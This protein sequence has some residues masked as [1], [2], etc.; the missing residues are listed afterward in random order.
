MTRSSQTDRERAE[1]EAATWL[2][3]LSEDP[4]DLA[5]AARFE[6]WRS[7]HPLHAELWAR[8]VRAYELAGGTP[9]ARNGLHASAP[10]E[11]AVPFARSPARPAMQRRR[12]IAAA[13]LLAVAACVMLLAAPGMLLRL[14]ADHVTATAEL[15]SLDLEDGSRVR[16]GPESAI[17]VEVTGAERRVRLLKGEAFFEVVP[18]ASRP[19][20]VVAQTVVATV[21]GTA[22]EVKLVGDGAAVAVQH[23]QVRVD[24]GV[25]P[26]AEILSAGDWVAVDG[27]SIARGQ[28]KVDEIGDWLGGEM[29]ARDR[30]IMEIVDALRRYYD[31]MIVV[32]D[33][34]FARTRVTGIYDLRHPAA[35]LASLAASHDA[36][37]RRISPWLLVVTS[38]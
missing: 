6:Q 9:A 27:A 7:A 20:R 31:G 28:R 35:T 25:P 4:D 19:F 23:G 10:S 32:Q 17:A 14:Q 13:A 36:T 3:A 11:N 24:G 12:R 2:V 29:V 16:L 21:L 18:D 5:L 22:F 33:G 38:K 26:R 30:P 34:S 1:T 15:R 8:T 37:M